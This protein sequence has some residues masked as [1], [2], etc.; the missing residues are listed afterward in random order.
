MLGIEIEGQGIYTNMLKKQKELLFSL[1][2][3]E[4]AS[5]WLWNSP[6][7]PLRVALRDSRS[8]ARVASDNPSWVLS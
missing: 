4:L 8:A 7:A 1:A 3:I 2:A 6:L 5:P